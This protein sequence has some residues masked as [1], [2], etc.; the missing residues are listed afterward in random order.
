MFTRAGTYLWLEGTI[1]FNDKKCYCKV[2]MFRVTSQ[3]QT[4][5]LLNTQSCFPAEPWCTPLR[6]FVG[7]YVMDNLYNG[8]TDRY[9]RELYFPQFHLQFI[10]RR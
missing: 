8:P 9:L 6:I 3:H 1:K 7:T 4:S 2:P 10:Y 5:E